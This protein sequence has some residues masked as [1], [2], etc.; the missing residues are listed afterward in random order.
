MQILQGDWSGAWETVKET[1]SN[2]GGTIV[3]TGKAVF[4][5]LHTTVTGIVERIEKYVS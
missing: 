1:F 3:E 5:K 4:E 2:I